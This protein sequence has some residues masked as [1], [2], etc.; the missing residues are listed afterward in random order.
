MTTTCDSPGRR[1]PAPP[2]SAPQA[3][4]SSKIAAR[5]G[6]P[7]E[8]DVARGDL[9]VHGADERDPPCSA[10]SATLR[11]VAGCSHMRGCIAGAARTGTRAR[12]G[13]APSPDRRRV[14]AP[15]A[16][17]RRPWRARSTIASARSASRTCIS[18]GERR[19]PHVRRDRL[20]AD[21]RERDGPDEAR[22]RRRHHRQDAR[23]GLHE[24]PRDLDG[25]VRRDAA[26]DASA[27][28]RPVEH[29]RSVEARGESVEPACSPH[30]LALTRPSLMGLSIG[31]VG[32]PN[33]GKSTLFNA[34]VERQGRGG[35]LPLLHHRAERRRRRRARPA[36]RR[37]STASSTPSASCRRRSTSST[38]PGSCAARTR[39]RGSATSFCRTSARSTR[40]CRSPAASTTRTSSTSRTASTRWRTS[41]T[42]TTELCLKDLDTVTKRGDRA[43]EDAQGEQPARQA[44]ASRSA[45]PSPSTSTTAS[46][47]ARSR[48]PDHADA[49]GVFRE[50]HLLTAKPTFYIANVDE[51][52]LGEPRRQQ[53]L[54]GAQAPRRR[55]GRARRPHLRRARGADRR[56]RSGRPPG[57]PRERRAEGAGAPRGHARRASSCSGSSR[58]SRRA[59]PRSARGRRAQGGEGAA[60]RRR[61]PHGLREGLHQGRGHLVGGLREARRRVEGRARRGSSRSRARNT[62]CATGTSCTSGST[63][64]GYGRRSTGPP[65]S[66]HALTPSRPHPICRSVAVPVSSTRRTR[67]TVRRTR[68]RRSPDRVARGATTR[69]R[70]ASA[71]RSGGAR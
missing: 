8:P 43:Q 52:S 6:H 5:L 24:Q 47:P 22:R 38:S 23:A 71:R 42:V 48:C 59:R 37:R 14:P 41:T 45:T 20:A 66:P 33:V 58:S 11:C 46:P 25:L 49:P 64:D 13:R 16:R 35:E 68:P 3:R 53:A 50:M 56:A 55:R 40:S 65:S 39:A 67:D 70:T 36:P 10:S 51:G 31:I 21:A 28:V 27:T 54:P 17:A 63:C 69:A 34:L 26:G 2:P 9:A 57:F 7:P 60:G 15:A 1:S 62:S 44:R 61:H 4:G 18:P 12:R 29:G 32:L 30:S 19:V